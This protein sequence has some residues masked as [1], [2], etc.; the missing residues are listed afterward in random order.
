MAAAATL[1]LALGPASSANAQTGIPT[2]RIGGRQEATHPLC[3]LSR[4]QDRKNRLAWLDGISRREPAH[5]LIH[6]ENIYTGQ[7]DLP[8]RS[9]QSALEESARQGV[10]QAQYNLLFL[11]YSRW[12]AGEQVTEQEVADALAKVQIGT[13]RGQLAFKMGYIYSL[14]REH[15][16]QVTDGPTLEGYR[17]AAGYGNADA[18]YRYVVG[19]LQHRSEQVAAD[20]E[21]RR[22]LKKLVNTLSGRSSQLMALRG[23]LWKTGFFEGTPQARAY[24]GQLYKRVSELMGA[25]AAG[26]QGAAARS[27]TKVDRDAE[28]LIQVQH[29]ISATI[30]VDYEFVCQQ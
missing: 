23:V 19:V 22:Y 3:G 14:L 27:V 8:M 26:N 21:L 29:L 18:A 12:V 1:G 28:R 16:L 30:T 10:P 7:L 9:L 17:L 11:V 25:R 15:V 2:D 5:L 24:Y 6:A 4:A 13:F 20:P